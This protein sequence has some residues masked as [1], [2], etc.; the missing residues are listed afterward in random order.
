MPNWS[1]LTL[2]ELRS[3]GYPT[4]KIVSEVAKYL[5]SKTKKQVVEML[6]DTEVFSRRPVVAHRHDGQIERCEVETEDAL[7]DK[8]GGTV[9]TFSYYPNGDIQDIT[10][11]HRDE[12]DKVVRQYTIHHYQDG[13]QPIR[14]DTTP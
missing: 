9:T 2:A 10:I 4:G 6:M 5:N 3:A 14:E 8:T 1:S 12:N 13:R 7:G 11:I